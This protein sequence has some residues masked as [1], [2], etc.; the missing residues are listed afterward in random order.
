MLLRVQVLREASVN[1]DESSP[2]QQQR[3]LQQPQQPDTSAPHVTSQ[4]PSASQHSH[5][6]PAAFDERVSS[7]S[8]PHIVTSS[9]AASPSDTHFG[10]E[11][12]AVEQHGHVSSV[13]MVD[14]A[15]RIEYLPNVNQ[16]AIGVNQAAVSA[17]QAAVSVNQTAFGESPASQGHAVSNRSGL[18]VDVSADTD[19]LDG[20]ATL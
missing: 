17:D 9:A 2:R 11:Q 10:N 15:V 12:P 6:F 19:H 13:R 7:A 8:Q 1:F 20:E 16:A 4:T 18:V 3:L 14:T 5:L